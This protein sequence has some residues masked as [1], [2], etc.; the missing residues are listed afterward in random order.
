MASLVYSEIDNPQSWPMLAFIWQQFVEST[1]VTVIARS[2]MERIFAAEAIDQIFERYAKKQ[3]QQ[4]LLFSTLV[5]LMSLVVCGICRSV[6]AAYRL[7]AKSV[8]V[9]LAALYNKL[10][11]VEPEVSRGLME[12]TA[13]ELKRIIE[14]VGGQQAPLVAGYECRIFDGISLA[15]TEK[16]LEV[17]RHQSGK[18]L[19]G[20]AIVVYDPSTKL[21]VNVFP[22]EDGHA[23]ERSLLAAVLEQVKAQQVWMGDRNFCTSELLATVTDKQ[24]YFVI[25]QH[26][27]FPWQAVTSLC[28]CGKTE[29][30][31]V[32]EQTIEFD[33][34]GKTYRCR[35]VV[36]NL[37]GPTRDG[38]TQIAILTNLPEAVASAPQI[39]E[40]YRQRW[41][42]ETCFGTLTLNFN[43]EI[44]TLAYP[45]AALFSFCL[46]LVTYNI[47][48]TVRAVLGSVHGVDK[49][50]VALSDYYL[51]DEIQGNYRGMMV[52]L[53]PQSWQRFAALPLSEFLDCLQQWAAQVSLKRFLKS[54]RGPK[55]KKPKIPYDPKHP[56]VSTARL[57]SSDPQQSNS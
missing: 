15:G 19:P 11:R 17:L 36:V 16:R 21:A 4:E 40:F 2:L 51:V 27:Q 33:Y 6:N 32:F 35:R 3:Y 41:Q 30:G 57:L 14:A 12:E 48:M 29:T 26:G 55:K 56:H 10:Q 24:A 44:A 46:A 18:P 9:S 49:I 47:L 34:N 25:R 52:A 54:P 5:S 23:Q 7:K 50:E 20:K 37:F 28:P 45:K 1:P 38:E 8:G 42:V 53:P 39:A 43:G 13:A 31:E 22:C